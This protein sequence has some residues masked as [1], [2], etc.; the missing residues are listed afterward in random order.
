[1]IF[2]EMYQKYDKTS[3]VFLCVI[4]GGAICYGL[5]G[6]GPG[7]G[8]GCGWGWGRDDGGCGRDGGDGGGCEAGDG[9]EYVAMGVVVVVVAVVAIKIMI[10]NIE[11]L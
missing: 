7:W 2:V 1:M 3:I 8:W 10:S 4:L 6:Y 5:S 9:L 11:N